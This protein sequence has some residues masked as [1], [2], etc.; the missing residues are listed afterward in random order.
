[1]IDHSHSPSHMRVQYLETDN[2]NY[3]KLYCLK[4]Q[5]TL[6]LLPSNKIV[7]ENVRV[8]CNM[9]P[10]E[11]G[12]TTTKFERGRFYE[13]QWT[14]L[15]GSIKGDDAFSKFIQIECLMA[16]SFDY[17]FTLNGDHKPESARGGSNFLVDP[18]LELANG[19]HVDLDSLQIQTVLTKLLGPLNEWKS[20]LEITKQSGYN[21]IHFTPVQELSGESDSSYSVRDHLKLMSHS[22]AG[23]KYNLSDLKTL[24]EFLYTDWNMFSICDLVYNHMSKD[25]EFLQQSPNATYNLENSPHLRPAYIL[26]RIFAHATLDIE[27]GKLESRGVPSTNLQA[28]HLETLRHIL[29][30]ELV[31]KYKIED[32]FLVDVEKEMERIKALGLKELERIA[33]NLDDFKAAK[34]RGQADNQ[35]NLDQAWRSLSISQDPKYRRL[36]CTIDDAAILNLLQYEFEN[37]DLNSDLNNSDHNSRRAVDLYDRLKREL[38]HQNDLVRSRINGYMDEA[39]N[40]AISNAYYHF[41]ADDGPKYKK[42][43]PEQP[44]VPTYF[45]FPFPDESVESDELKAF[46]PRTSVRIQ[47]YNGW[48]MNDDALKNFA[49]KDSTVFIRRQLIPWGDSVKLRYGD[50]PEDSP[51]LWQHM[52]EY[53]KQTAEIFHGVRLDNCHSTPI[54][55]AQH[56][57]DLG[58]SI[59]PNLFVIAELFT[60]SVSTD[61]MFVTKLGITSL[62]REAMSAWNANELGR[63]V[64]RY[65]GEPVGSFYQ[66]S[67]RPLEE[68]VAHAI[69]FDVTHDNKSLIQ[70]RSVYDVLPSSALVLMSGCS[71][72]STRGFDEMVPIQIDVVKEKRLYSTWKTLSSSAEA[73]GVD[74]DC[75]ILKAKFLLNKMHFDMGIKGFSQLYVDQFDADTTVVTR[76]NPNTHE[77]VI[78]IARTS[79]SHPSAHTFNAL[80]RP[81]EIPSKI[82]SVLLEAFVSE[83]ANSEPYKA[84][85]TYVNGLKN[86]KL[87]LTENQSVHKST[88]IDRIDYDGSVSRVH[89]KYFPPGTVVAFKVILNDESSF[90]LPYLRQSIAQLSHSQSQS[91]NHHGN[92]GN[93]EID[94]IF[95]KLTFDELNILLF[96]CADEE[97]DEKINSSAYELAD[98]GRLVYCG[99]QGFMNVLE[100]ERLSNNLGHAM[101]ENLRSGNWMMDYITGRLAK[102]HG[103]EP[104]HRT[105]LLELANWV[106]KLFDAVKKMPRY[107]IPAYFDSIVTG[108]YT[109]ALERAWSLMSSANNNSQLDQF[110]IANASPFLRLLAIG[111][112]TLAGHIRSAL[113]PNTLVKPSADNGLMLSLS[114]GLPHFSTTIFRNWGRDTFIA[115]RGLLLLTNRANDAKNLILSYA[116]TLRHGLIPNLL[117]EGKCARYNCRDSVWWWLKAIADYTQLAPNGFDILNDSVVRLYP[118]DDS[119]YPSDRDLANKVNSQPL[120]QIIQ[121]AL[122]KHVN[123]LRFR[124][125]SAGKAIDEHMR[126]EGFDME[127]GVNLDT[128]FVFGGNRYNC[129]TW[130][131]KMGSSV[132]SGSKGLPA[133]PRDG[134]AVEL[135]GLS[136]FVLEWLAKAH[137]DGKY[138]HDGVFLT[139]G[140]KFSWEGWSKKI[141]ANFE[142]YFWVDQASTEEHVNKRNI[143][144]DSYGSSVPWADYQLRP[145][146][147]IALS[148]APQMINK[149]HAK[150]ALEQ[151]KLNLVNEPN[152]VG[153]KTLDASDYNYCGYYD[154]SNDSSDIRVAQGFNYHQGPE[155]LWPVGYYLKAQLQYNAG[156]AETI[157][158]VNQHL[159]KL[160]DRM[161]SSDWKSLPELTNKDGSF[162]SFSCDAQAW[163][164]ATVIEVFHQLATSS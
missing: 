4:Q 79:F 89:F 155:W 1:M 163:S 17:Y 35:K 158:A 62:V 80:H 113:L 84:S 58:R 2:Y 75:G 74:L 141:D 125:R 142:K 105:G 60:N 85:S 50:R 102:Y 51:E 55:V 27:K 70:S 110:K 127:I 63:L 47:A 38:Y 14:N 24:I 159:G 147:L 143:Y 20:R 118:T 59:R 112:V 99:L 135:V 111:G 77:S 39:V 36:A 93:H 96:R 136:R 28:H 131:D 65:G 149:E 7:H 156:S 18:H 10:R 97:S 40:N 122:T 54:H 43:N 137:R 115:L 146:F 83:R 145:N 107:L 12:E 92:H 119:P 101:F 140:N 78:L 129:G 49:D 52:A 116:S 9:P 73:N 106:N 37:L 153:I 72:G 15:P 82:E 87:I 34:A 22:N 161:L 19:Q 26:D 138:P 91:Q 16:G 21:M 98:Y 160:Y 57:M 117:G 103:L 41:L 3:G 86:F 46:D 94:S 66:H 61:N 162:C 56:F 121:E 31:P 13:Y 108:L 23:G 71:V 148:L 44:I 6:R 45:Y 134:S 130:M 150:L 123:G 32:F 33:K 139:N 100:K 151:C 42:V 128:G 11:Q 68:G 109:K 67:N 152:T 8:F 126:S 95:N 69:F 88:F 114:A 81:L 133:T 64:H 76:H 132:K 29:R 90:A 104:K 157:R 48:V 25:A 120:S 154:N 144:K 5:W 124:E 164:L 30:H 53:T